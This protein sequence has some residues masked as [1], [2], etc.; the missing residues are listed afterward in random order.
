M[1]PLTTTANRVYA[2]PVAH[3]WAAGICNPSLSAKAFFRS[4]FRLC[5]SSM[6]GCREALRGAD[7]QTGIANSLHPATQ[8]RFARQVADLKPS[9]RSPAMSYPELISA[10]IASLVPR[11]IKPKPSHCSYD[12][13]TINRMLERS[14]DDP[15]T[16]CRVWNGS[17]NKPGGYGRIRYKYKNCRVHRLFY[18]LMMGPIPEGMELMH[19]CDNPLCINPNH[20]TPGTHAENIIDA[21]TKGRKTV[22]QGPKHP[23]FVLTHEQA[24]HAI[25][26]DETGAAI[27]QRLGVSK[28]TICRLRNGT[29]WKN[30]G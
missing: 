20:L 18:T 1:I 9:L 5:P 15:V 29:T 7:P 28:S 14:V 30:R 24:I 25:A 21:Y 26:S 6:A 16:G 13:W 23:R 27:A 2:Q 19:T 11:K 4:A 22:A 8:S 17:V 10:V 12:Y 3:N